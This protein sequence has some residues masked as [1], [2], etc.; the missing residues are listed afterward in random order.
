MKNSNDIIGNRTHGLQPTAPPRAPYFK[1]RTKQ[2]Q[3]G[4][5]WYS[6]L[7]VVTPVPMSRE[8]DLEYCFSV[9]DSSVSPIYGHCVLQRGYTVRTTGDSTQSSLPH[10]GLRPNSCEI[11]FTSLTR[12][13]YLVVNFVSSGL[14]HV[15]S[16]SFLLY[17]WTTF[18]RS[19]E[20][21]AENIFFWGGGKIFQ[22]ELGGDKTRHR[23]NKSFIK[24]LFFFF[25]LYSC[26]IL[27]YPT[28]SF[29]PAFIFILYDMSVLVRDV[30]CR[31]QRGFNQQLTGGGLV[32]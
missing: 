1:I 4:A 28:F 3:N 22:F 15:I 11:Y 19:I 9:L 13:F 24:F 26:L 6:H 25:Y 20:N 7:K 5:L 32:M 16:S 2:S 18:A 17:W 23:I 14:C 21:I 29:F 10:W 27:F 30:L 31:L 8:C 12:K